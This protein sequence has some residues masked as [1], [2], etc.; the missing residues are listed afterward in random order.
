M[1]SL[2]ICTTPFQVMNS[3]VISG[4][5]EGT[6]SLVILDKFKDSKSLC[7]HVEAE[8]V[9]QE[10]RLFDDSEMWASRNKSWLLQRLSTVYTYTQCKKLVEEFFPDISAYT[11]IFVS[12]RAQV[13][14]LLCMYSAQWLQDVRIHYF[15]DGL[16][17]YSGSI[18]RVKGADKALR[19]IFVGKK[20]V[21]FTYD[22]YLYSPELYEAY[23]EE[24]GLTVHPIRIT[25]KDKARIAR[26]FDCGQEEHLEY[27]NIL[28]D[29]IP[30]DEFTKE[31][32]AVYRETVKKILSLG[33]IVVKQHPRNRE[34]R[35]DAPYFQNT[36]VPFEVYCAENNFD[37][38]TFFTSCSTAVFTPKLLYDQEPRIVF[39]YKAMD[40]YRKNK[41]H[42]CDK[43]VSCLKDMYRDPEK[44]KVIEHIEEIQDLKINEEIRLS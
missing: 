7:G 17:S 35:Y 43:L 26:I 22:L 20:A 40:E 1:N 12:S 25:E 44:I 21:E 36:A 5:L 8:H 28:F 16:G 13:N 37:D 42:D 38:A 31:G 9:F 24:S 3:V 19:R 10:T 4:S 27:K 41:S 2:F 18:I 30:S 6:S 14:R 15:D 33:N 29:T 23:Q 11:D 39:L 32:E 34:P